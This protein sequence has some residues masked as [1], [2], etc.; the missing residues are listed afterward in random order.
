M[1]TSYFVTELI[2]FASMEIY[3][4]DQWNHILKNKRKKSGFTQDYIALVCNTYKSRWSL[5]ESGNAFPSDIEWQLIYHHLN[6]V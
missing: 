6:S 4:K 1:K 3:Y 5:Y 2:T